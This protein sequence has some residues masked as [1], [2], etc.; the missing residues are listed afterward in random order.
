MDPDASIRQTDT[1]AAGARLSAVQKGYL[2]DPFAKYFVPRAHLQQPRP[3]LINVGTYTRST[4]IDAL[5]EQWLS[6]PDGRR[7]QIVSL[8]SGS[9]TRFWRIAVRSC[10]RAAQRG[11]TDEA[12]RQTG[13]RKDI[14]RAYFEVDFAE[15]TTKKAM[16][17]RKS[18]D[19]SSVLGKPEEV[20]IGES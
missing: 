20:T 5:V 17:I 15:N 6:N 4:A 8:G 13:P 14:L 11:V 10:A 19:L 16:A 7:C 1:D 12:F 2:V 3:P 9:D 18:S